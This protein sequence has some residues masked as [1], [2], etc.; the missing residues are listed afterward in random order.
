LYLLVVSTVENCNVQHTV[1]DKCSNRQ[2]VLRQSAAPARGQ[3]ST[4]RVVRTELVGAVAGEQLRDRDA[5]ILFTDDLWSDLAN[6]VQ[7]T[8]DGYKAYL[9]AVDQAPLQMS[10][11]VAGNL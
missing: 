7:L 9:E 3:N 10:D 5:A 8:S 1:S 11:I 2:R 4:Y 6:R